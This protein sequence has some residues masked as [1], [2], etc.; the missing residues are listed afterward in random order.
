MG[1]E[2]GGWRSRKDQSAANRDGEVVDGE[3]IERGAALEW[4][5]R[6]CPQPGEVERVNNGMVLKSGMPK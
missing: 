3:E 4:E 5:R 6:V 1:E 2:R